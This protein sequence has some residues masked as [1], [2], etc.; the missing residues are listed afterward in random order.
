MNKMFS[1][2]LAS[3]V[4]LAALSG[5]AIAATSNANTGTPAAI[6]EIDQFAALHPANSTDGAQAIQ[7]TRNQALAAYQQG[8]TAAANQLVAF[9]RHELGMP[10]L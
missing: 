8:D 4:S 1:L 5:A 7:Q 3:G 6:V 9:A 10:Q 2:I